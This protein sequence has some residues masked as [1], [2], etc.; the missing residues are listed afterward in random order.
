M[1]CLISGAG[2]AGLTLA[3]QLTEDGHDVTVVERAP[4]LRDAGYMI[5]FLGPGYDTAERMGLLAAL[6]AIHY[7]IARI[8]FLNREG[9]ERFSIGYPAF[10]RLFHN[11]H[12]NFL[13]GDLER[14]LYDL[15][16]ERAQFR[17]GTTIA[18]LAENATGAEGGTADG[19]LPPVGVVLSDGTEGEWDLVAG[20]DGIHSN[21]RHLLFGSAAGA[22]RSLGFYTAAFIM[23]RP[24]AGLVARNA[25]SGLTTP[26][27]QA[28]VYPIRGD[29]LATF[30]VWK[31]P[32]PVERFDH[33]SALAQLR[34]VYGD[35]GWVLPA[36]LRSAESADI[37][38]DDV[39]QV[40]LPDWSRGRVVLLGDAC[41]CVSLMAG[42]GASMAMAGAA[43][44]AQ[45]IQ[46]APDDIP[47][48]ARRYQM[49]LEPDIRRKQAAGRRIAKYLVPSSPF[50]Q[51]VSELFTRMVEWPLLWR[52]ARRG[53]AA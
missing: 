15:V 35:L 52:I 32:R 41:Y 7:P 51:R 28:S 12:F 21:V 38:F 11:R 16:K 18:R 1:R 8:R 4:G 40:V 27:R 23:D 48:A 33:E 34:E 20:A 53:L 19:R 13:R 49:R 29:R 22:V 25:F 26:G 31:P 10:R 39:A 6:R 30:F 42:Q 46:R 43:A 50:H 2:I 36:L 14:V 5:D 17:F 24:P 9:N 47:G 44:L 37:Y 45:E 3:R